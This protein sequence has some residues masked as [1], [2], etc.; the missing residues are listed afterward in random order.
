[1]DGLVFLISCVQLFSQKRLTVFSKHCTV[2][3]VLIASVAQM[4]EHHLAKVDV[5][6]PNPFARSR[7][8]EVG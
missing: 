5:E 1:M 7:F 3:D 8:C 4:V 2:L 6:G